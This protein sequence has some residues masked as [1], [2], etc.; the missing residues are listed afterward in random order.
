MAPRVEDAEDTIAA[1][2][3]GPRRIDGLDLLAQVAVSETTRYLISEFLALA[4][5][6]QPA[7]LAQAHLY[8]DDFE[9]PGAA[10]PAPPLD[11]LLE[12]MKTSDPGLRDYYCFVLLD[13]VAVEREFLRE[14]LVAAVRLVDRLGWRDRLTELA[15]KELGLRKRE[16]AD[17]ARR[18][19]HLPEPTTTEEPADDDTP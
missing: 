8:F 4:G 13:F 12:R 18:L 6:R 11:A 7:H 3:E 17:L 9:H 2:I 14:A 10:P 19:D 16:V 5:L 15:T 1:M